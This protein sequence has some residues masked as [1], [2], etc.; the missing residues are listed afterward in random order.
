MSSVEGDYENSTYILCKWEEGDDLKLDLINTISKQWFTALAEHLAKILSDFRQL[1]S[2]SPPFF[3]TNKMLGSQLTN[4]YQWE[5]L[6]N[7]TMT[8]KHGSS[9]A[10]KAGG[11]ET[12][13]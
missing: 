11:E 4:I 6:L 5:R 13:D 12:T 3:C 9:V 2:C 1:A 7:Y 8:S 10:E